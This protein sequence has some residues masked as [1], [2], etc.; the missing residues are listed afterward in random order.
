[1]L[2]PTHKDIVSI[3]WSS[4]REFPY[5]FFKNK[6]PDIA[7]ANIITLGLFSESM[8][9]ILRAEIFRVYN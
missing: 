2:Q 8:H 7:V 4:R 5:T 1:M 3:I 9:P 6:K